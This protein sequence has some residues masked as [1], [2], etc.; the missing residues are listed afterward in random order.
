MINIVCSTNLKYDH[1]IACRDLLKVRGKIFIDYEDN[2]YCT[3]KDHLFDSLDETNDYMICVSNPMSVC[4]LVAKY[5]NATVFKIDV[6]DEISSNMT[7]VDLIEP[8]LECVAYQCYG[9]ITQQNSFLSRY[10]VDMLHNMD[11]QKVTRDDV[12]Q[13]IEDIRT[14]SWDPRQK[15]VLADITEK[16]VDRVFDPNAEEDE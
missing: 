3:A 5:P 7:K 4:K 6:K 14:M 1:H 13:M 12:K 8:S 11:T 10:V 9:V 16:F 2:L 15:E